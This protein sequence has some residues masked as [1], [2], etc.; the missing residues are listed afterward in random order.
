MNFR[1]MSDTA[2]LAEVGQRI[3]KERLNQNLTQADLA[4]QAGVSRRA[5]QHIETDGVCTLASLIRILRALAKL[6]ALDSFIPPPG[7]SPVQMARLKGSERQRATGRRGAK[8][9]RR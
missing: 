1:I 8:S 5:L 4:H 9:D 7:I 3:Q 2:V 6:D